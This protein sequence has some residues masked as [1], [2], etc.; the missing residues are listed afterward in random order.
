M[1]RTRAEAQSL[2]NLWRFRINRG[3]WMRR[4]DA[5]LSGW[6]R[7]MRVLVLDV[8]LC[9]PLKNE[10]WLQRTSIPLLN[11]KLCLSVLKS[12]R[13]IWIQSLLALNR[14][15]LC[16]CSPQPVSTWFSHRVVF[17]VSV[18][19]SSIGNKSN[20]ELLYLIRRQMAAEPPQHNHL[21]RFIVECK[22]NLECWA[23]CFQAHIRDLISPQ[24]KMLCAAR[25]YV[26][27]L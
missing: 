26:L 5:W 14:E 20:V 15:G 25:L 8:C 4:M 11:A 22:T 7:R 1:R 17:P 19:V 24:H 13:E 3:T 9:L 18:P 27:Q 2:N 12:V 6:E 23:F 10:A 21:N 16:L